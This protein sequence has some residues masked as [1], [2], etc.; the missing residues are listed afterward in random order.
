MSAYCVILV[1]VVVV[2]HPQIPL[3]AISTTR[4]S[5]SSGQSLIFHPSSTWHRQSCSWRLQV[6]FRGINLFP[7]QL[8]SLFGADMPGHKTKMKIWLVGPPNII[9][10]KMNCEAWNICWQSIHNI[11]IY[12]DINVQI[13]ITIIQLECNWWWMRKNVLIFFVDYPNSVL[14]TTIV[15]YLVLFACIEK[16]I[17]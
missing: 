4:S 6:R 12:S 17:W 14:Q 9:W 1:I 3:I 5:S 8:P 10:Q 16:E 11:V 7:N 13:L 15:P 2:I